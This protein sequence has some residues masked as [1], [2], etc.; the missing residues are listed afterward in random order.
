MIIRAVARER[1]FAIRIA[2]GAG[3]LRV[4]RQLLAESLLLGLLGG[5]CRTSAGHSRQ[6]YWPFLLAY[7]RLQP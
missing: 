2:L 6:G 7:C 1:E 5:I 4:I 3:R